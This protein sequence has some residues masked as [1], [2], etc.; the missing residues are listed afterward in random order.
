MRWPARMGVE[1]VMFPDTS[2]VLDAPQTGKHEF[3]PKGGATVEQIRDAGGSI[4]TIGL[5]LSASTRGGR[6]SGGK[7]RRLAPHARTAHRSAG[8]RPLHRSTAHH[9]RS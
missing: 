6:R 2:D 8:D 9:R 4:G 3:Y 1:V 5:G 7:V